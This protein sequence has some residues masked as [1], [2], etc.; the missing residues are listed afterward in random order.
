MVTVACVPSALFSFFAII[1]TVSG[2]EKAGVSSYRNATLG[3]P[4]NA[5]LGHHPSACQELEAR[6]PAL[7]LF[8]T[9][10]SFA[11]ET[12]SM[13]ARVDWDEDRGLN[14]LQS[15]G[16]RPVSKR[17]LAFSSPPP[18]K[19]LQPVSLY[20]AGRIAH[21]LYAVAGTC[22]FPRPTESATEYSFPPSV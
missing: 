8:S 3:H 11:N 17:P 15:P 22:Q 14:S 2:D 13:L 12:V 16:R 7:T 10:I 21:S 19:K 18:Q 20:F 1:A 6:F 9:D 4:T 5:T